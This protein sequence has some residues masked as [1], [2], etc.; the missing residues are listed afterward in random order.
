MNSVAVRARVSASIC[1][2][3]I[4]FHSEIYRERVGFVVSWSICGVY[5]SNR[6]RSHRIASSYIES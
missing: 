1:T 5:R 4:L 2:C 3:F 6:A